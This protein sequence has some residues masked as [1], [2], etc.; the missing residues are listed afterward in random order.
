MSVLIM[1]VLYVTGMTAF[2]L[3]L[4]VVIIAPA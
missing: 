1:E 2:V 3:I 4:M